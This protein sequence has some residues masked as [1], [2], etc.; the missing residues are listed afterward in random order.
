MLVVDIRPGMT[1]KE[2]VNDVQGLL[3]RAVG[4]ESEIEVFAPERTIH[5]ALGGLSLDTPVSNLLE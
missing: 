1:V 2:L 4:A 5:V 3:T